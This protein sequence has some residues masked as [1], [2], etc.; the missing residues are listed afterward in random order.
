M[1]CL[2]RLAP[3]DREFVVQYYSADEEKPKTFRRDLAQKIGMKV[4]TMRVR[5]GRLRA[6]LEPCVKR[7]L[8]SRR[9][10]A[11]ISGAYGAP[12]Q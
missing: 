3:G 12:V 11:R 4:G 8:E 9:G 10:S 7:C 2:A 5:A 6:Q 1:Q